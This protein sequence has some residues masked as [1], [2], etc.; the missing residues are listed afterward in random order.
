MNELFVPILVKINDKKLNLDDDFLSNSS[1][2]VVDLQL[3]KN[4]TLKNSTNANST[5]FTNPTVFGTLTVDITYDRSSFF[6][7]QFI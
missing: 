1:A 4:A 2:N 7:G 5:S 3:E 6:M